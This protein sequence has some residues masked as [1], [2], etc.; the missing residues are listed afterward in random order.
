MTNRPPSTASEDVF[1]FHEL[2]QEIE[3][4]YAAVKQ[5]QLAVVALA[6]SIEQ[7]RG[8]D[9]ETR[10]MVHTLQV[11]VCKPAR[12]AAERIHCDNCGA[13]L[14]HHHAEA[15]ELL[16]CSVCGWSDFVAAGS[17]LPHM[18]VGGADR[19]VAAIPASGWV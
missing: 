12:P 4:I 10:T 7:L 18:P 8:C 3:L 9:E 17:E 1:T 15:G 2:R 16:I 13:P 11:S 6:R 19:P 14:E 5:T